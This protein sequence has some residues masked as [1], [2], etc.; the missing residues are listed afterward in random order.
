MSANRF[1]EV[2][3]KIVAIGRNYAAHAK[4]LGNEVPS[5]PFFFL[6]PTTSYIREGSPIEIPSS[7]GEVHHEVEL[8]VVIGRKGKNIAVESAFDYVAG[9]TLALDLTARDLQ[10]TAKSKG[11]PWTA[12]K[13]HD[14]FCPIGKFLSKDQ[15][16]NPA[17]VELWLKIDGVFKQKGSTSDMIFNIPQLIHHVSRVMTL[18]PGDLI[19]TGTPSGVGP[20]SVGKAVTA[21]IT[22]V[23]EMTFDVV[24]SPPVAKL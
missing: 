4:E 20:L 2:G 14:T 1:W 9:Y 7:I 10:A 13:G 8:G 5:A 22:G 23:T 19:L 11:L 16:P 3:K 17:K 21:G 18:E 24:S 6:K 15:I 12:A